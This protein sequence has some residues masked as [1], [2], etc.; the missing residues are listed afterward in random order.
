LTLGLFAIG[1]RFIAVDSVETNPIQK[2]VDTRI[3]DTNTLPSGTYFASARLRRDALVAVVKSSWV[4]LP[5]TEK[6]AKL[7][8]LIKRGKEFGFDKVM[9]VDESGEPQG[10]GSEQQ[11]DTNFEEK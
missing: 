6:R 10:G 9:L 4:K 8:E 7:D 11:I 3:V 5:E 2:D 1:S